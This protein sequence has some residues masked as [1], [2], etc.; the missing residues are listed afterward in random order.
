M[1]KIRS[2]LT[3]AVLSTLKLMAAIIHLVPAVDML[4]KA[5][6]KCRFL[7]CPIGLIPCS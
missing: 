1:I 4:M 3:L 2:H 6:Q 5:R 7:Q